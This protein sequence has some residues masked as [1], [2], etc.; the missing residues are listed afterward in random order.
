[1]AMP[2]EE[3]ESAGSILRELIVNQYQAIVAGGAALASLVT[4]NPLP[5][6]FLIGTELILLPV[7]DSGPLR[8]LVKRR[9]NEAARKEAASKRTQLLS[10]FTPESARIFQEMEHRC[11][12]IEANYQG[13]HGI[14]QVYLAEQR[15]KLDMILEGC[16][17]RLTA[18]QRYERMLASRNPRELE[19]EIEGLERELQQP[20]LPERA[21]AA[22]QK[23]LELKRRLLKSNEEARGTMKALESELDSMT[24]LLEVL[25]QSSISMRD[26]QAI[27]EELD[28]I[29]RQSE[30]SGK[31]VREMEALLR[32]DGAE[33]GSESVLADN[34]LPYPGSPQSRKKVKDR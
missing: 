33:W 23:N 5:L 31:A 25:H 15:Q 28:T 30:D 12:A 24:S 17:H 26:P 3:K 22:V 32:S 1:M 21:R 10:S 7:L 13:L 14:S 27:S 34:P 18:L 8:R 9:R 20:G 16:I 19:R 29:V 2:P 6:L 4:L 11:K